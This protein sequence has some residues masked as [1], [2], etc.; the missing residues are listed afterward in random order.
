MADNVLSLYPYSPSKPL[1]IAST[2]IFLILLLVHFVKLIKTKTWFAVPLFI[3]AVCELLLFYYIPEE[4]TQSIVNNYENL[5]DTS[6]VESLGYTARA[7]G[8]S[9][10]SSKNAYIVQT[11]LILLAPI[12]FAATIYMFMGRLVLASGHKKASIIRP[13]WLTKVF[14]GGDI[15]CFLVQAAGASMLVKTDA[16]HSTGDLGKYIIL[17]GLLIQIVVFGFFLVVAAIFHLR[18]GKV[19][20]WRA[21]TVRMF[22]WRKYMVTL[23]IASGLVTV[24]NIFRVV[25]YVMGNEGYL[26]THEWPIYVFDA[27]PMAA[28][29]AS[30]TSWYVGDTVPEVSNSNADDADVAIVGWGS[31]GSRI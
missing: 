31:H 24:R 23:Y 21:G 22:N 2:G 8:C 18:A 15:L 19:K 29:L 10:P 20:T 6:Q 11:M 7:Y 16:S 12:L 13:T 1:A 4:N 9:H 27:L 30:C 26:L 3:G 5:T 28:A 17:G 14:L 25:E